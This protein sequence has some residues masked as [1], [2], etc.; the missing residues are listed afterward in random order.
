MFTSTGVIYFMLKDRVECHG[1]SPSV[2]LSA[3]CGC[4]IQKRDDGKKV[5]Q[6]YGSYLLVV[7][8]DD[9]LTSCEVLVSV[10]LNPRFDKPNGIG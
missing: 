3:G 8:A 2:S 1:F 10:Q 5:T 7:N 4:G 6:N 9:A